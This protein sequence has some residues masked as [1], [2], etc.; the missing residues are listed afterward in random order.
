MTPWFHRGG[1]SSGGPIPVFYVGA[2]AVAMRRFRPGR[3][4]GLRDGLRADVPHRRAD[5]PGHA[6]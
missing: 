5:Q 1:V 2:E 3:V 4:P 6:V